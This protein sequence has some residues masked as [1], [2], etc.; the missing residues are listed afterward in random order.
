MPRPALDVGSA[1]KYAPESVYAWT[2]LFTALALSG[3]GGV[4]MW[5]VIVALPAASHIEPL[6]RGLRT[7]GSFPARRR[8]R[9]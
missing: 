2:R 4:G 3:I 9:A 1:A 5:S 7:P 6:S 8:I